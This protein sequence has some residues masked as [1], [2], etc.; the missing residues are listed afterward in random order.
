MQSYDKN[1]KVYLHI[2]NNKQWWKYSTQNIVIFKKC[3]DIISN[4]RTK[5]FSKLYFYFNCID[6]I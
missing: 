1:I 2:L 5:L 6:S 4:L 3:S